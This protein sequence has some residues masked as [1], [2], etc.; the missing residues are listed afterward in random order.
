MNRI[1]N[2]NSDK[3]NYNDVILKNTKKSTN[4]FIKA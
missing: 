4:N 3:D 1:K 2:Q